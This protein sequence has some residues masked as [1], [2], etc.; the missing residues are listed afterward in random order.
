MSLQKKAISIVAAILF[1]TLGLNTAV[2]IYVASDRYRQAILSKSEAIGESL[3][4]D[5]GKVLS[6]GIP[7]KSL[8]GVNEKLADMVS[9][10]RAIGYAMITDRNGTVLFQSNPNERKLKIKDEVFLNA[11]ASKKM[12]ETKT[13]SFY[14][15][16]LPLFDATEDVAGFLVLGVTLQS[17][18]SQIYALLISAL[19]I[20]L[21]SFFLS[22]ALV[23]Y[24]ISKFI[25][26]P[27]MDMEKAAE[28]IASGDLTHSVNVAGND[29]IAS[30]GKAINKTSFN[31]KD[32]LLKISKITD[33]VSLVTS[34]VFSSSKDILK[35]ADIQKKA[36]EETTTAT[37]S[38]DNS[39]ASVALGSDNLSESASNTSSSILEMTR[40]IEKVAEGAKIFDGSAQETAA[41]IEEMVANIREIAD[42]LNNL[43]TS[44]DAIASSIDEVNSTVKEIEQRANESVSLAE[45]VTINA[46]ETGLSAIN[47][48]MEGMHDIR[49]SV[50]SLSDVI[51][52]LGKRSKDIGKILNVISEVTDQTNLLSLNAAILSAQAGEHGKSFAVVADHIRN[53]A[54]RTSASTK[55]IA[56]M[57]SAVQEETKSSIKKA[58]EGIETVDKGLGLVQEVNAALTR[59]VESSQ[60]STE[61]SRAIQRA[62][63]EQSLVI[64][65]ITDSIKDMS[66]QVEKISLAIHEQSKGSKFILDITEKMKTLSH[67]VKISTEEQR[68]GS[69]QIA[70]A[71]ENITSQAEQIAKSTKNQKEES[72]EIVKSMEKIRSTTHNLI[73]S[74]HDMSTTITALKDDAQNLLSEL[75]KFR[76][77]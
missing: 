32:M 18:N 16:F 40:S 64:K 58:S 29:E 27:I 51:N 39:I 37:D 74:S 30:L 31:L 47:A 48:A 25:A 63:S 45:Q 66:L 2:L 21:V 17:I 50:G 12:T 54:E 49:T 53:L 9:G 28:T 42:S 73:R 43:S 22:L 23:Y 6:L 38:L 71:A 70:Q 76:V 68:I 62:T 41:S 7:L 4:K 11:A 1:I 14:V 15:L 26:K 46:S 77:S 56:A 65:Q 33:S 19:L 13:S 72:L 67:Q 69:V 59:I 24:S 35:I 10:N 75:R 36:I 60:V 57:I 52:L 20:V 8:E 34:N 5:L 61:M 55:E 3:T 44:S